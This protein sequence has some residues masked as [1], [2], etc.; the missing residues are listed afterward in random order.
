MVSSQSPAS[1]PS[2][3]SSPI[4]A[5]VENFPLNDTLV[6][7]TA[8]AISSSLRAFPVLSF[9]GSALES[10]S[11]AFDFAEAVLAFALDLLRDFD[12]FEDVL[13]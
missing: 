2:R 10:F 1:I 13:L 11:F 5:L 8:V 3:R 7:V 6:I 9:P 4:T 12:E